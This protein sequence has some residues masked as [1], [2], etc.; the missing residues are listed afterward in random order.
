MIIGQID[1]AVQLLSVSSRSDRPPA[2]TVPSVGIAFLDIHHRSVFTDCRHE[3]DMMIPDNDGVCGRFLSGRITGDSRSAEPVARIAPVGQ[4][5]TERL[6]GK[7]PYGVGAVAGNRSGIRIVLC[8]RVGK[9]IRFRSCICAGVIAV[10]AF[11]EQIADFD[12]SGIGFHRLCRGIAAAYPEAV[13][14]A[15][16]H[17]R[18]NTG[19]V[20]AFHAYK[21][22]READQMIAVRFRIAQKIFAP[23]NGEVFF[24][25]VILAAAL[26]DPVSFYRHR[27]SG[28][29]RQ[30]SRPGIGLPG[31]I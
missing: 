9:R 6:I 17:T 15:E 26:I 21:A 31:G 23:V 30:N 28:F 24:C 14:M 8:I 29:L 3:A 1:E 19:E 16:H 2:L 10:F 27:L 22:L 11:F 18:H 13:M 12:P 4:T 25:V 5:D 7:R 20:V